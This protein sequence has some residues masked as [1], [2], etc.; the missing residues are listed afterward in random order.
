M[1][2]IMHIVGLHPDLR[3]RDYN[4]F[5]D[6]YTYHTAYLATG[7]G[8]DFI[9]IVR[10]YIFFFSKSA[11]FTSSLARRPTVGSNVLLL[12]QR[13]YKRYGWC[14]TDGIGLAI[15]LWIIHFARDYKRVKLYIYIPNSIVKLK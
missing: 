3:K 14:E 11:L 6:D 13:P 4:A 12:R 2:T 7:G 5:C 1:N 10:R 8:T 9:F 15:Y